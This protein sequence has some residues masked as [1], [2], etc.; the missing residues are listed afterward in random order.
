MKL[1]EGNMWAED[2]SCWTITFCQCCWGLAGRS[3]GSMLPASLCSEGIRVALP[4]ASCLFLVTPISTQIVLSPASNLLQLSHQYLVT[5][6]LRLTSKWP[7]ATAWLPRR[8]KRRMLFLFSEGQVHTPQPGECMWVG[9]LLSG[10]QMLASVGGL[11]SCGS[12]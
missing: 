4:L 5:S 12:K 6:F 9:D 2:P 10:H 3:R 8:S 1:L 11:F 7:A